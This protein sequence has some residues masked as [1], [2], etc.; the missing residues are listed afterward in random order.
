LDK[1]QLLERLLL[2]RLCES[3]IVCLWRAPFRIYDFGGFPSTWPPPPLSFAIIDC[4]LDYAGPVPIP[5]Y[6]SG[7]CCLKR[8]AKPFFFDRFTQ[9]VSLR[10]ELPFPFSNFVALE[11][12]L[13]CSFCGYLPSRRSLVTKKIF[14]CPDHTLVYA[15]LRFLSHI[16]YAGWRTLRT[17]GGVHMLFEPFSPYDGGLSVRII[18]A[19]G[20]C[21][22]RECAPLFRLM[23]EVRPVSC[24]KGCY[25]PYRKTIF[26]PF[27]FNVYPETE[28]QGCSI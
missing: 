15:A 14:G 28:I 10:F 21:R 20:C 18:R 23:G 9:C 4:F 6:L 16:F 8:F 22:F 5:L 3:S 24:E 1:F 17:R 7:S 19:G 13:F 2:L 25:A 27:Y 12:F 11:P 26:P